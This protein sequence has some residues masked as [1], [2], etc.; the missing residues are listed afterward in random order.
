MCER[1]QMAYKSNFEA[2][3]SPQHYL[4]GPDTAMMQYIPLIGYLSGLM[5]GIYIGT[6]IILSGGKFLFGVGQGY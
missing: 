5:P 1:A 6:S 2:V 4:T 3:F